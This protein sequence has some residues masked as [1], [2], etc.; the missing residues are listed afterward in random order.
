MRCPQYIQEAIH[1]SFVPNILYGVHFP[2]F[3]L[4]KLLID[5][6]KYQIYDNIFFVFLSD[7]YFEGLTKKCI[8][9]SCIFIT[10]CLRQ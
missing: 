1:H 10:C 4:I 6:M 9:T 3:I 8:E 2:L 7:N 5:H